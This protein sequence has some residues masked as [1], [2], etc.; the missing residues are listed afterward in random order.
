M[1][2][3]GIRLQ[4]FFRSVIM[5]PAMVGIYFSGT[6]NTK[7]CA[8]SLLQRLDETASAY[9]VEDG[10]A[11][12]AIRSND[13]I[14]FAYPVYYSNL[15]KI[16]RDFITDNK[17]VWKGKKIF[18]LATM[19]LFS[20]DGAG[21]SA[22]LFKKFGAKISGGLHIKM[23]D[24]IGD[25]ALLKKSA[26][27]NR[28]IIAYADLKIQKAADKIRS[29]RYPKNGLGF[30]RRL[31][32][33][34][35]QR[36]YFYKK[37]EKYYDGIKV[38]NDKCIACGLC[39]S[40]CPMRNIQIKEGKATFGGKCTLCYRCFSECPRQAITIIGKKAICQYKFENYV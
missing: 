8:E 20:G 35:G 39:V 23:P 10:E 16:V 30:T 12:N 32:G 29:E 33:L 27:D 14:L 1:R 26:E 22:R 34:F 17:A 24:C 25:V 7:H 40:L 37:T 2:R 11:L 5:F 28:K 18:I 36:L 9:S 31:A 6:G 13:E 4:K 3:S 38:D 15:P 19:G 21:C